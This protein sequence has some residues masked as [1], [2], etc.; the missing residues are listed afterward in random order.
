MAR[1]L[2]FQHVAAEPA[3]T[4]DALLRRRGH[5]LRFVNFGRDP[6]AQPRVQGY[7]GLIVLGGAMNVADQGQ[8]P[9]LRTELQC[10][11]SA[12]R[13]GLPVLG[14]CLGAQLLAHALGAPVRRLAQAE[15]GWHRI[16]ATAAGRE[17]PVLAPIGRGAPVFQWHGCGFDLPSGA[18]QLARSA[19][20]EQQAFRFGERAY[21][22]QF[23]LE[24]DSALI[25]R[26]L[27]TPSYRRE[28]E[29]QG[30]ISAVE[31][32]HT[33]TQRLVHAQA[34]R[35]EAVFSRFLDLAGP[36]PRPAHGR[37]PATAWSPWQR[38]ARPIELPLRALG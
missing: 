2:V 13:H 11:E 26:W 5:R 38:Q 10:I 8:R 12:L 7:D 1:F 21:G 27:H 37:R 4:L 15:I 19:L 14:I 18:V 17:D 36:A 30:A 20:C 9:H 24:A 3:G 23:H 32:V 34:A 29:A 33:A 16:E 6:E 31:R 22:L 28:L 25:Q 35:A